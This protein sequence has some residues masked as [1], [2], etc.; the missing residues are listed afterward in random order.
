MVG[1]SIIKHVNVDKVNQGGCNE[2]F[3]FPGAKIDKIL[4]EIKIC[5][6]K[7]DIEELLVC[8]GTNHISKENP[9]S[10]ETVV[11]KL[12]GMISQ[13]RL[14]MPNTKLYVTGLL[15]KF[16][17]GFNPGIQY[18]NDQLFFRQHMMNFKL[19]STRKFFKDDLMD[20]NMYGRD[21][22]H[23]NYK[24]VAKLATSFMFR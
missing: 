7:F 17:D 18:I 23:L 11:E 12:L 6:Q 8:V 21:R 1:D 16:H 24:G 5:N 2:L 9:E 10:P 14:N 13:I 19:I 3:S 22:L 20:I 15:P 4:S